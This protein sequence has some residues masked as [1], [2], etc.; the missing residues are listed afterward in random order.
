MKPMKTKWF[1]LAATGIVLLCSGAV[2]FVYRVTALPAAAFV[3]VRAPAP[4]VVAAPEPPAPL[5]SAAAAAETAGFVAPPP[6]TFTE[7]EVPFDVDLLEPTPPVP[8]AT[9]PVAAAPPAGLPSDPAA[10]EDAVLAERR[11]RFADQMNQL[12][13]RGAA[14]AG[15]PTPPSQGSAAG[16]GP[17]PGATNSRRGALLS[18]QNN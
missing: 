1:A 12:N 18:P 7:P 3:E 13:R 5:T 15:L 8:N 14:R 2:I 9:P 16:S 6:R 10:L 4:P 17:P 11:R